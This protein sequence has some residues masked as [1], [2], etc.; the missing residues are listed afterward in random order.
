[1]FS[2][3][4]SIYLCTYYPIYMLSLMPLNYYQRSLISLALPRILPTSHA[5]HTVPIA[6]ITLRHRILLRFE[7]SQRDR[8][9]AHRAYLVLLQPLDDAIRVEYVFLAGQHHYFIMIRED[10]QADRATWLSIICFSVSS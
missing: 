2:C 5:S 4:V 9:P 7:Q 8:G 6:F 3:L 1:M 10:I